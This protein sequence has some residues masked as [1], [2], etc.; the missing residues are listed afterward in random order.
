MET[1]FPIAHRL[2]HIDAASLDQICQT[3]GR[4]G[5]MLR[6]MMKSLQVRPPIPSP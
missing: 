2:E 5:R 4:I 1:Q 6:A 3:S